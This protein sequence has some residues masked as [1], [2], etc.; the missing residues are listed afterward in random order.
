MLVRLPR[1]ILVLLLLLP[2]GA[3]PHAQPA[4]RDAQRTRAAAPSSD[5][6]FA[7]SVREW[8]T[9]PEFMSPLVD[10]LPVV[11]GLPTPKDVLGYHVGAPKRLTKTADALAYYRALE[12][13]SPRI[14]VTTIG[15]T[16]EGREVNVVYIASESTMKQLDTH[17]ASLGRLADPR[18]LTEDEARRLIAT[19]PP[20]YHLMAGLHSAETGPPEMLME[21]AYRLVAEDTPLV[22]QVRDRIIVSFTPASDP[23]GRD[24]YV[25]WYRKYMVDIAEE[26]DRI[27]GPPYWGKY[28]FHDNNRDINYSQVTLRAHLDWYLKTHPPVMHDLH[29]SVPFLYTFSGQAPQN[30]NLD[31][32]VYG[33][34]P[35]FANFEMM[36]LTKYGMPGVWTH[37]FVDMWSPGYLAF[38]SSNHN[39]LVRMYETFGNGGATTMKRRV[40]PPDGGAGQTSREWYRPLPPYKEVTWSMRNNTNYMQTAVLSA[41]QYASAFPEVLVENFYKKSKNSLESGRTE[42]PYAYVVPAGQPDQTRVDMLLSLLMR[43]GIEVSRATAE[44]KVGDATYPAGSYVIRRDQPYGRLVKTLLEKQTFPDPSLRTYDDTGWTMGLMLQVDVKAIADKTVL[45]AP[46]TRVTDL[47]RSGSV[48]GTASPA[49]WVVPHHGSNDMVRLRL[50]LGASV[51]VRA[52]TASFKV[53]DASYP[54]GSFLVPASAGAAFTDAVT[55]LGL[56]ATGLAEMPQAAT[57]AVDLPRL[58]MFTTW[59]RTQEV[60]WVRHAFD[61]FGIPYDLI[62]KER[63][64]QGGLRQAYDV[65]LVPNQ[66]TT[67]KS[68]VYDIERKGKPLAYKKDAQ[69]PSLG[70]YGESDDITGGMGLEGVLELQKFV[71]DGGVLITLGASSYMPAEFGLQRTVTATR[72]TGA[73]YAPGPIVEVELLR[74]EHP[75]FFGY[76][77]T[78][79]PVRYANGP[80][81][82]VPAEEATDQVL[83]RFTG[84]DEGVLSGLMRGSAEIRRRPALVDTP[85]GKG[86]VVA[87]ATNPCYRWQNHGEFGMLF[88]AAVLFWNDVPAKKA[89]TPTTVTAER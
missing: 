82:Q 32:I 3:L 7:A 48:A 74:P 21:L 37:G 88:N 9:G 20:M 57:V 56:Q 10:H 33:E 53:G 75:I 72:P 43:Q 86:R 67:G 63:I 19:T 16:D 60:G 87:F 68:L 36:Q 61:T 58:A 14:R 73:F 71:E 22:R 78:K 81:F 45:D 31:P 49:A 51:D 6:D 66:A 2:L 1:W 5:A 83:M 38:M 65:I 39:G 11:K 4:A 85:M 84:G 89:T 80:L 47:A 35:M 8:T 34:L 59:G 46:V 70:T 18:G 29:E 17:I 25:D 42:A 23:D 12:K 13:A 76:G 54:A 52:A 50:A 15:K 40:A 28:I 69:F 79:L 55:R 64:R 26:K 30:P 77:K 27:T 62:Y 44:L 24:R 41:L